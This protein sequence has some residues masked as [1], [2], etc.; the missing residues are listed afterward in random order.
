MKTFL[1]SEVPDMP[2]EDCLFHVIPAPYEKTVSYGGG[3]ANG[4]TAI[5]EASYQ[6]EAYDGESCPCAFGIHT[7][8]AQYSL[9]FIEREI[10]EV[11]KL[12]KIPVMLGG[13]HTVTV[14][15]LRALKESG[16]PFGVIQF[17]AHAD[18]RREY[19]GDPLSHACAL[20]HAVELGIPLFQIGVRA[21]SL[22]EVELRKEKSIPYLDGYEIGRSG[23]PDKLLPDDFPEKVYVTFDV[24]GLDPSIMP[25]TGTPEPG[26]LDWFQAMECLEQI[27][28]HKTVIGFDVVELAPIEKLHAPD[29]LVARMIYNFMGLI[30][31]KQ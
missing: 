16:E 11:L 29:F 15:A 13:E 20:R 9:E 14:S 1:E 19:E 31:R 5:L 8:P 25:A 3:T 28:G 21:L 6:L 22:P 30:T 7:R 18:L 4:P 27:A 24:D 26:G 2:A 23:I 10:A 17:D 12:G